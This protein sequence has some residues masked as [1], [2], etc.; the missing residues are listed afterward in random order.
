MQVVTLISTIRPIQRPT[1]TRVALL[2]DVAAASLAT[3]PAVSPA[4]TV[5]LAVGR[6]NNIAQT[7]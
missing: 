6:M 1:G 2:T 3:A 5:M 4:R 7:P